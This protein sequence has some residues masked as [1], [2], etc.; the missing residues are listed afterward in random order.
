M[1]SENSDLSWQQYICKILLK[2]KIIILNSN[3]IS[4]YSFTVFLIK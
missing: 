1:D 2:S 3:I 4:Q